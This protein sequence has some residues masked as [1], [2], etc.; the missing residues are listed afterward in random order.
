M[1]PAHALLRPLA[2]L[3]LLTPCDISEEVE[4]SGWIPWYVTL[5]ICRWIFVAMMATCSHYALRPDACGML[6]GLHKQD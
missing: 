3:N 6:K 5:R 1:K 2:M 4:Q